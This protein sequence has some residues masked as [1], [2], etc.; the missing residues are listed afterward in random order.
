MEYTAKD[1][2]ESCNVLNTSGDSEKRN[3]ANRYLSEF[4]V[5]FII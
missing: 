4:Q 3:I 1:V 5:L 2:I